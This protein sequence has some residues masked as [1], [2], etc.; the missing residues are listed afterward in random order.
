MQEDGTLDQRPKKEQARLLDQKAKLERV[1]SGIE[2]M[3]QLPSAVFLIDLKKEHIAVKE[4]R[5]LGIPTVAVVDTNCDPEE[6]TYP[7]PGNDDAI[8]AIRLITGKMADA[9]LEGRLESEARRAKEAAEAG[10][11]APV[12]VLGEFET[13]GVEVGE[14]P[15]APAE[16]PI[17]IEEPAESLQEAPASEETPA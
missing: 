6:V 14:E 17:A 8:R 5:R 15:A 13:A 3:D 16:G 12:E 11:E 4:C 9:V 7:I 1:L 2:G 10:R